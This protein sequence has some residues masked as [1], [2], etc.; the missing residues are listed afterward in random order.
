M[1]SAEWKAL[2]GR[3]GIV[4]GDEEEYKT[5]SGEVVSTQSVRGARRST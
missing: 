1:L 5:Q 3:N 2:A 4:I